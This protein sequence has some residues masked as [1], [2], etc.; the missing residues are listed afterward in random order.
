[1]EAIGRIRNLESDVRDLEIKLDE[2][3][4]HARVDGADYDRLAPHLQ[5]RLKAIAD[6]AFL[7]PVGSSVAMGDGDDDVDGA[8]DADDSSVATDDSDDDARGDGTADEEEGEAALEADCGTILRLLPS[9]DVSAT[10]D[11]V[12]QA[13]RTANQ[14]NLTIL[15]EAFSVLTGDSADVYEDSIAKAIVGV[16]DRYR[17]LNPRAA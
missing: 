3:Y 11:R 2:I 10:R 9:L 13:L 5:Q 8:D 1:M 15:A 7:E 17:R 14:A 16:F 4:E 6:L 12:V